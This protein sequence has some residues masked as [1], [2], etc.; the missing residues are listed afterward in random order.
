MIVR[1]L[2]RRWSGGHLTEHTERSQSR[3]ILLALVR[4]ASGKRLIQVI[5]GD[6]EQALKLAGAPR[7]IRQQSES[8]RYASLSID[9]GL[10]VEEITLLTH[11]PDLSNRSRNWGGIVADLHWWQKAGEA[12]SVAPDHDVV[13]MRVAGMTP[14]T[15]R[16]DGKIDERVVAPGNIGIHA[17]GMD[18]HWSWTRP[19]AIMLF[20]I[21]PDLIAEVHRHV[22]GPL[23][24]PNSFGF[25]DRGFANYFDLANLELHAPDG[26][27]KA[28]RWQALSLAISAHLVESIAR[29][30][31]IS[32]PKTGLGPAVLKRVLDYIGDHW[33]EPLSLQVLADVAGVSRFHF[34]RMFKLSTGSSVMECVERMRLDRARALIVGGRHTLADIAMLSGF[35]DQSHFA[36]RF[37]RA[38]DQS[39]GK[40]ARAYRSY[41]QSGL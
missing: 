10:A 35:V 7:F 21:Q 22:S 38:F 26:P 12:T 37:R 34:A 17:R 24:L 18:S 30:E 1:R 14:L 27:A 19:G 15:Q 9:V 32:A 3:P 20:R 2:T 41:T 5:Y 25:R 6:H 33:Q 8:R 39:P 36:R 16:R 4:S 28:L 13:A 23:D 40:F 29:R 31:V 11:R